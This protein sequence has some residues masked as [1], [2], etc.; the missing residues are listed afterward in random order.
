[1][2]FPTVNPRNFLR[3]FRI[4]LCIVAIAACSTAHAANCYPAWFD[5]PW[6]IS[7]FLLGT[8]Q[9]HTE[10]GDKGYDIQYVPGETITATR[11]TDGFTNECGT[12]MPDDDFVT[13]STE[14]TFMWDLAQ[15]LDV[16]QGS[17]QLEGQAVYTPLVPL[18]TQVTLYTTGDEAGF[19]K[20]W[21]WFNLQNGGSLSFGPGSV[22]V[23]AEKDVPAWWATATLFMNADPGVATMVIWDG[24]YY[25]VPTP[26]PATLI[27][28]G[29][30]M[31]GLGR[32]LHRNPAK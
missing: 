9:A 12:W 14:A 19:Q 10:T 6:T 24:F 2:N 29:T 11:P 1:M 25:E 30:A 15:L 28:L 20:F 23:S 26:E 7:G 32:L 17:R 8:Y 3:P 27:L 5:N 18:G 16:G 31:L 4:S 13:V 21:Y 22:G